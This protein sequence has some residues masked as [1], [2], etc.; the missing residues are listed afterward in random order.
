ML[1]SAGS[2]IHPI[3]LSLN[4]LDDEVRPVAILTDPLTDPNR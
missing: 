2:R 1:L 4:D 3:F